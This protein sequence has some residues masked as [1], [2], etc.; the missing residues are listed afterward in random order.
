MSCG[1]VALK[2]T[3]LGCAPAVPLPTLASSHFSFVD[4]QKVSQVGMSPVQFPLSL[5]TGFQKP[6]SFHAD[7]LHFFP[8]FVHIHRFILP[9]AGIIL[10][11]P[12]V[13]GQCTRQGA[14]QHCSFPRRTLVG[15]SPLCQGFG[16]YP[17]AVWA[18]LISVGGGNALHLFRKDT[19][20][21]PGEGYRETC[22][23][24]HCKMVQN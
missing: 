13:F 12:S 22:A 7:V 15:S 8:R 19:E 9:C 10:S 20:H 17:L 4:L 11:L 2:N 5:V 23:F 18:L 3:C 24:Y 14:L 6:Y 16:G 1:P 21:P